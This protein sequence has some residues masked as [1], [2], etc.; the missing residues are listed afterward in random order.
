MIASA[1]SVHCAPPFGVTRD[2]APL[3]R[4]DARTPVERLDRDDGWGA[5][6]IA[7][8]DGDNQV[9]EQLL[10]ELTVWLRRYFRRRLTS[11]AADDAT[12]EVLL[13]IHRRRYTYRAQGPF[14]PWLAA[15]ARYKWIDRLRQQRREVT[16]GEDNDLRV[17][18]HGDIVRCHVLVDGLI[19]RLKPAQA[20]VIRLV[21][22]EG[23]TIEEASDATGQSASLVKVNIHRGLKKIAA[24][25]A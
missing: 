17:E 25:V 22:I 7:A 10:R 8:R 9:Y 6:M 24:Y 13:A 3:A 19:G 11:S 5:M 14:E 18:D 4:T 20:R 21:K 23:A 2:P 12:Q 1:S 16:L 15:I